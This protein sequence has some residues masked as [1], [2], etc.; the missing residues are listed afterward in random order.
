MSLENRKRDVKI[1]SQKVAQSSCLS[2]FLEDIPILSSKDGGYVA[3]SCIFLEHRKVSSA[4]TNFSILQILVVLGNSPISNYCSTNS[5]DCWIL[6]QP[7]ALQGSALVFTA[8]GSTNCFPNCKSSIL[9][10]AC[11]FCVNKSYFCSIRNSSVLYRLTLNPCS[12]FRNL[13][14]CL[15]V[16]FFFP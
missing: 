10:P 9:V 12:N 4:G 15:Q 2:A 6:W 8:T 7:G 13:D 16:G 1:G 11:S 5:T 3:V 14:L